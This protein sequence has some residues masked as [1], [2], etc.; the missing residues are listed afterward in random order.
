MSDHFTQQIQIKTQKGI[1]VVEK[2][3]TS[4]EAVVKGER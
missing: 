2:K 3:L 4:K 1:C